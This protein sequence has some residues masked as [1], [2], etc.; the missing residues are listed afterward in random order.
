MTLLPG[1]AGA[2]EGRLVERR[3][4]RGRHLAGEALQPEVRGTAGGERDL[5]LEDD[6]HERRKALRAIPERRD[7]EA[8]DD[9]GEMRITATKLGHACG[10]RL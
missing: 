6:L 7:A 3:D 5:L 4:A 10:E 2:A 8:I 1:E 9:R